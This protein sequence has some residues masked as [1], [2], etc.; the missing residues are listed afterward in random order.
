MGKKLDLSGVIGSPIWIIACIHSDLILYYYQQ[1]FLA[2]LLPLDHRNPDHPSPV[3]NLTVQPDREKTSSP[4]LLPVHTIH[5][6]T[7][8]FAFALFICK[9]FWL[10]RLLTRRASAGLSTLSATSR[11][12]ARPQGRLTAE[13][14]QSFQEDK[15]WS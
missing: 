11:C 4:Y 2:S 7:S 12:A 6:P 1:W 14:E 10:A 15:E 3:S 13:G 9:T 8:Y 5:H